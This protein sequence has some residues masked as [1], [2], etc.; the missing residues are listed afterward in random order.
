MG[1]GIDCFHGAEWTP[2]LGIGSPEKNSS[3]GQGQETTLE[4]Q[5]RAS[6]VLMWL[7]P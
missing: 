2:L 6:H 1:I 3:Q 4:D 5:A 7:L